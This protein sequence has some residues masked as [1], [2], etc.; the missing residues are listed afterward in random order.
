M[1][2]LILLRGT[3]GSGKT[4]L[5]ETLKNNLPSCYAVAADD[6]FYNERGEYCFDVDQLH[7]AHKWCQGMVDE[8]MELSIENIIVHN[9]NTSEKEIAPYI[10]MAEKYDYKVV[11]LV[12]EKRHDNTSVHNVPEKTL[13]KQEERLRNSIK[14]V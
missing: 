5:A 9:T 7:T 8:L 10:A 14:L 2:T 1:K 6:F 4:T 12:V 11:S 3:S 13:T